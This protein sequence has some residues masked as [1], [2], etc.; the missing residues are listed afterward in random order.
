MSLLL[1]LRSFAS[2]LFQR[3]RI[4]AEMEEELRSHIQHRADDLERS[5]LSRAEAE[6][7]ARV[8]FGGY[9]RYKE[10]S[11]EALGGTVS[12]NSHAGRTLRPPYAVQIPRF[13]RSRRHYAR[14][15][16]QRQC[17]CLQCAEWTDSA[18]AECARISRGC[19]PSSTAKILLRS[20]RIRIISICAIGTAALMGSSHTLSRV[21]V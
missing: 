13:H 12:R 1:S 9:E 2:T 6:R 21:R 5:G 18:S 20:T 10:E 11:H 7:R 14:A 8:E 17:S 15:W 16:N 3:S 4:D 19:L